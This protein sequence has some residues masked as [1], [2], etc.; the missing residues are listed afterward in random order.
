MERYGRQLGIKGFGEASQRKLEGA[1]VVVAGVGGLGSAASVYLAAAGVGRIILVD[2]E[3][4]EP[5]NLNRQILHWEGDIGRPKVESASRKLL[6]LNPEINVETAEIRLTRENAEEVVREADVVVDALDSY[7]A[8]FAL[9][10]ACVGQGVPMVHGAVEGLS[11][12]VTTVMPGRGPCLR[13][14]I[15]REPAERGSVPILGATAGIIGSIQAMEAIKIM[16]GIGS[17]LVGR[18]LIFSGRDMRFEE[19]RVN[20]N[21]KCPACGGR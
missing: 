9:N 4:V 8:R 3:R 7:R 10:E 14:A 16:A 21:P 12:Q 13:C 1:K 2:S 6:G 15:P 11:G 18:M 17:P 20:R 19:M 5:S